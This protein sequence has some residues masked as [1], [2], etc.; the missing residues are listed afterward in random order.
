MSFMISWADRGHLA[1][2]E[3]LKVMIA[4]IVRACTRW[5]ALLCWAGAAPCGFAVDG[6]VAPVTNL[7][8]LQ[9]S[10]NS[11]GETIV[12]HANGATPI[13]KATN[14]VNATQ[15]AATK[16]AQYSVIPEDA[17]LELSS[18]QFPGWEAE[19]LPKQSLAF[20]F[21]FPNRTLNL[22]T[23]DLNRM[24]V[25]LAFPDGASVE[26]DGNAD[27]RLEF[28]DDGT[29]AF[30]GAGSM[31]G[32]NADGAPV[33]FGN[34]F[35]PLFGGQL[36]APATNNPMGRFQRATPVNPLLFVGQIETGI[37]V[38][39]GKESFK[40][41]PGVEQLISSTNGAKIAV[42]LNPQ[43]RTVDWTV[44]RGLFRVNVDNF[45]CW[46][47]LG[48][49]GQSASMQWD[50]NGV[51]MEIKNKGAVGAFQ[52]T[53]LVN[54]NPS[55]NVA[56]GNSATFQYGRTGDCSTFVASAAGGETTLYNAATGRYIRL[57]EGN[58]SIVSGSPDR[59]ALELMAIH[60]TP[61]RLGWSSDD[62]VEIKGPG[63]V[64][65]VGVDGEQNF[66]AEGGTD[67]K[68][69]YGGKDKL[70]IRAT[71]GAIAVT[72]E[73]MPSIAIEI[74]EASGVT[75][76]YDRGSD[77]FRVAAQPGNLS[78]VGVRTATGFY[79]QA[80]EGSRLT[81]VV[82]RSSFGAASADGEL[83]FTETAGAGPVAASQGGAIP[84]VRS[85]PTGGGASP[86]FGGAGN[87]LD[88]SRIAQPPVSA[89]E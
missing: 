3:S 15:L 66:E 48:A 26:M 6:P 5:T 25:K 76:G 73:F 24:P 31:R 81:F 12:R 37:S 43:T 14:F 33:R 54:L 22:Q 72:P 9:F 75:L 41:Q 53:V 89:L 63:G 40:L 39:I 82:N 28:M 2:A 13:T 49:P 77:I 44:Q 70:N 18:E 84:S 38:R 56:V 16:G 85:L 50:T 21:N 17:T 7:V 32:L 79:P 11:A 35:P 88:V 59:A 67:V 19:L 60:K 74:G 55:L 20:G 87:S 58:M 57:D 68:V 10:T 69:T 27:G 29:Y 36:I 61:L 23:S 52:P 1:L 45:S 86:L 8:R 34:V 83:V 64:C 47:A 4:K 65:T 46:K 62:Q 30:F 51:M 80:G 78:P 42:K 71:S